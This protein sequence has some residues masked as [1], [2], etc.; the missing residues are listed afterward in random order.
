MARLDPL[1]PF[2]PTLTIVA[3]YATLKNTQPQHALNLQTQGQNVPSAKV[4]IRL[5]ICGLKCSFC[6]RLRHMED[7]CLKKSAKGLPTTTNFLEVL[8]DDE[9]AILVELNR[10]CGED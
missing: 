10:I 1:Q 6:F 2:L 5:T 3:N 4:G 9:E 8:V 7:M